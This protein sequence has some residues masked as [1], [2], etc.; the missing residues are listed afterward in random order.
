VESQQPNSK[1]QKV[2]S[3]RECAAPLQNVADDEDN[4]SYPRHV[5]TQDQ[6]HWLQ[7]ELAAT[8]GTIRAAAVP[9]LQAAFKARFGFSR[10][11]RSFQKHR[12]HLKFDIV[13][14]TRDQDLWLEHRI[15]ATDV[16]IDIDMKRS[17]Q[18][19]FN[20]RFGLFGTLRALEARVRYLKQIEPGHG[21][22]S[23]P[24]EKRWVETEI[25]SRAFTRRGEIGSLAC[26]YE[27]QFGRSFDLRLWKAFIE[28]HNLINTRQY[29]PCPCT[30]EELEWL[31]CQYEPLKSNWLKG[32][33]RKRFGNELVAGF[34]AYFGHHRD[35]SEMNPLR[36][37][38]MS[39]RGIWWSPE[40][41]QWLRSVV[42]ERGLK[43][44]TDYR[45]LETDFMAHF[46][47]AQ[48]WQ[49][50]CFAS[51]KVPQ[52]TDEELNFVSSKAIEPL[53]VHLKDFSDDF[54]SKFEYKRT[55][56]DLESVG[57]NL[58]CEFWN[59][60]QRRWVTLSVHNG[61]SWE[62]IAKDFQH[63]FKREVSGQ[64]IKKMYDALVEMVY[65]SKDR[66]LWLTENVTGQRLNNIILKFGK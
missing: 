31:K 53:G 12:K 37:M 43:C 42:S 24:D 52:W 45:S 34:H 15:R 30:L 25:F 7:N 38:N 33:A 36:Q 57:Q 2:S 54:E 40:Q 41:I 11:T 32:D 58:G 23:T 59:M 55:K 13:S 29:N 27:N 35:F 48:S 62:M 63:S 65:S 3:S 46:G 8:S 60:N 50:M 64:K 6:D 18:V 44:A 56:K 14:W 10:S 22:T 28:K 21:P 66:P 61:I 16:T 17:L 19:A 26:D 1:K 9:A 4:G 49:S 47:Y 39:T 20:S 51:P 5:W